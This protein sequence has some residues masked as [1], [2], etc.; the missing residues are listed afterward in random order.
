ME[1]SIGLYNKFKS[2]NCS[3]YK[4]V[5]AVTHHYATDM[6]LELRICMSNNA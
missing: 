5:L 6:S 3:N 2:R 4:L 1:L